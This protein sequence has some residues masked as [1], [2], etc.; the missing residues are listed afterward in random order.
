MN[1][2]QFT[3]KGPRMNNED[4]S[5]V[6]EVRDKRT[7]FVVC[8][9]MGGALL[10]EVASQ[11]VCDVLCRMSRPWNFRHLTASFSAQTDSITPWMMLPCSTPCNVPRMW[12][13]WRKSIK[14]SAKR[15]LVITIQQ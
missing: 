2:T 7:L 3:D 1:Y 14:Q 6:V 15:K 4:C 5:T 12:S 9:G 8:D 10:R 11:A 13:R